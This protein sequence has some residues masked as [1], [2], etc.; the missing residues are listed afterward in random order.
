MPSVTAEQLGI[1]LACIAALAVVAASIVKIFRREPPL[2]H[3]YAS[4]AELAALSKR[5]DDLGTEIREGF[6][7]LD[8][9]RSISIAGLHDDLESKTTDLRKEVKADI[10]GVHTRIND[11]LAAVS[12]L[13]GKVE[14]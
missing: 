11:V 14:G 4:K 6:R 13:K 9:K 8:S 7:S 3:E 12:E 1:F 5:V 2:H 10:A